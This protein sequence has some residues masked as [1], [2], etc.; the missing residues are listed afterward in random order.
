MLHTCP[1]HIY[2][3]TYMHMH[4]CDMHT[5]AHMHNTHTIVFPKLR[6]IPCP[7]NPISNLVFKKRR[8][9]PLLVIRWLPEKDFCL[10]AGFIQSWLVCG[11][12]VCSSMFQTSREDGPNRVSSANHLWLALRLQA[13]EQRA[14][15]SSLKQMAA[16]SPSWLL[17]DEWL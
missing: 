8:S 5:H 3:C 6:S 11:W 2:T 17:L 16:L 12:H 13:G 4:T 7:V 10:R 9:L 1:P 15:C 14:R